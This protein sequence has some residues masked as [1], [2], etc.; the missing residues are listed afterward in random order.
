MLI[1]FCN[2]HYYNFNYSTKRWKDEK[3]NEFYLL[4][5]TNICRI[6]SCSAISVCNVILMS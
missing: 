2:Y 5:V 4:K 3:N 1:G 6:L